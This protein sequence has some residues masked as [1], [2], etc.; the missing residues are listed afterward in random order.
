MGRKVTTFSV[1]V[2]H[3]VCGSLPVIVWVSRSRVDSN[4]LTPVHLKWTASSSLLSSLLIINSLP[5]RSSL[6]SDCSS[7]SA[8]KRDFSIR[9]T[10]SPSPS[11]P[12]SVDPLVSCSW[13]RCW[14]NSPPCTWQSSHWRY[15]WPLFTRTDVR[16]IFI[17][18]LT[19]SSFWHIKL[20]TTFSINFFLISFLEALCHASYWSF[21]HR[22]LH[23]HTLVHTQILTCVPFTLKKTHYDA[24][25]VVIGLQ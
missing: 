22:L 5:S 20:K 9:Y 23:T 4:V 24:T 8:F 19:N 10:D 3:V 21:P 13:S 14:H 11:S 25:P 2:A 7:E 17:I 12:G 15:L 18:T 16:S 6:P 1:G